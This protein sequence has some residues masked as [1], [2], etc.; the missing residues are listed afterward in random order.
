MIR[1]D[2]DV[3]RG[4]PEKPIV[5]GATD[6]TG[7]D[8]ELTF[9]TTGIRET[10]LP[11][12]LRSS[13]RWLKDRENESPGLLLSDCGGILAH[14]DVKALRWSKLALFYPGNPPIDLRSGMVINVA[15][16]GIEARLTNKLTGKEI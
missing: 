9:S 11:I 15:S 10:K 8:Y 13:V 16:D 5:I 3:R 1:F 2:F 7:E 12:L 6:Q 4:G 14:E